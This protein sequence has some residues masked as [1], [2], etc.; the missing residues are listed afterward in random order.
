MARQTAWASQNRTHPSVTR[1][2]RMVLKKGVLMAETAQ[3]NRVRHFELC[4]VEFAHSNEK[5]ELG[6]SYS[7]FFVT[8]R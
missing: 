8:L 6:K 5:L 3:A 2:W 4:F 7:F 1:K